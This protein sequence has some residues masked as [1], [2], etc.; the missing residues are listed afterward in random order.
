MESLY[1]SN[2]NAHAVQIGHFDKIKNTKIILNFDSIGKRSVQSDVCGFNSLIVISL[3]HRTFGGVAVVLVRVG[4]HGGP[5]AEAGL[6]S[7]LI[8]LNEEMIF[9]INITYLNS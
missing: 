7:A 2:T 6:R 8:G 9:E 3:K 5:A 1:K 4:L